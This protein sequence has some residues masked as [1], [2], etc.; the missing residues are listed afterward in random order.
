MRL[1]V[2]IFDSYAAWF[3]CDFAS[4]KTVR[5]FAFLG[6]VASVSSCGSLWGVEGVA[7]SCPRVWCGWQ[8]VWM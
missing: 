1:D 3:P 7:E 5:A 6:S 4:A 8:D 2:R